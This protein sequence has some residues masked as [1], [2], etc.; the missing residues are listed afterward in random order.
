MSTSEKP[1]IPALLEEAKVLVEQIKYATKYDKRASLFP[2]TGPFRRELYPK[3]MKFFEVGK[4]YPVV[5]FEAANQTG[6]STAAMYEVSLH[7]DGEYP[8]WWPGH[9]FDKPITCWMVGYSSET[10]K[11][12]IQKKMLGEVGDWGTGMIPRRNIDLETMADAKKADTPITSFRVKHKSGGFSTVEIKTYES[13]YRAFEGQSI[14][15]ILMDEEPPLAVYAEC[16]TRTIATGGK[17]RLSYTP[18]MGLTDTITTLCDGKDYSEGPKNKYNYLVNCTWWDVPHITKDQ[19]E[20]ELKNTPEYLR[21]AKSKGIPQLGSGAVYPVKEDSFIIAPFEIPKSWK[22]AYALDYGWT[23]PT[24]ILWGAINPD[25]GKVIFY[26]EH[27]FSEKPPMFHAQAIKQRNQAVGY[28]IPGCCDPSG[29]G[30]S[31]ADGKKSREIY[32]TEFDIIME[33][34]DNAIE[35]GIMRVNEWL[36]GGRIKVFNTLTNFLAEFRMYRRDSKGNL[37]GEDHLM[38]CVSPG[39]KV[40]TSTGLKNIEDINV[41]DLVL[42]TKGLKSVTNARIVKS[43]KLTYK[44]KTK[45]GKELIATGNHKIWVDGHWSSVEDIYKYLQQKETIK[46]KQQSIEDLHL[47]D[48][49]QKKDTLSVQGHTIC[50][51]HQSCIDLFIKMLTVQFLKE[52]IFTTKTKIQQIAQLK[53]WKQ[54]RGKLT[55]NFTQTHIQTNIDSGLVTTQERFNIQQKIGT[56]Q[57]KVNFGIQNI[58]NKFKQTYHYLNLFALIVNKHTIQ[59][60]NQGEVIV[61]AQNAGI[62]SDLILVTPIGKDEIESIVPN[63]VLPKVYDISV[64]EQHEFFANGILVHNCL[65]YF[66]ATGIKIANNTDPATADDWAAARNAAEQAEWMI[67]QSPNSWLYR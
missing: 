3:Q 47:T 23:K 62:L 33:S 9:K 17:I 43:N 48:I 25:D 64:D 1:D 32:Q 39:T 58:W 11:K 57:K 29:G 46:W 7:L 4:D 56:N 31:T 8:D 49:H 59:K 42:T 28:T 67:E 5:I 34:A 51:E 38:D 65:K 40:S 35:P 27:Y 30:R 41:G 60:R 50:M 44:I 6:K 22:R 16:S 63:K 26:S 12:V 37:T 14:E 21:D 61:A 66:M 53:I 55:E 15:L 19:R 13:G 24:A 54:L 52:L 36:N 18:L 45:L 2:A 20:R 10:V